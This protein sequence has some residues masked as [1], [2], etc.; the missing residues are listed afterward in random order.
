MDDVENIVE[1]SPSQISDS[2]EEEDVPNVPD[3]VIVNDVDKP[4]EMGGRTQNNKKF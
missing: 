1:T 2:I 4:E 3:G